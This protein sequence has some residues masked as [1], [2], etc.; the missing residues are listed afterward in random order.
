M[1]KAYVMELGNFSNSEVTAQ[2]A[3]LKLDLKLGSFFFIHE[4]AK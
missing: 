4:V 3:N 1:Y 2:M